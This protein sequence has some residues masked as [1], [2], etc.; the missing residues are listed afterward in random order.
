MLKTHSLNSS[1]L[2][3]DEN[4][5]VSSYLNYAMTVQNFQPEEPSKQDDENSSTKVS[6][7]KWHL[8]ID[9]SFKIFLSWRKWPCRIRRQKDWL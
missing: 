8:Q 4:D 1:N 9:T 2:K 6:D 7:K 5:Y 3:S